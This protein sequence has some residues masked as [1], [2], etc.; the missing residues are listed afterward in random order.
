MSGSHGYAHV[1]D[2]MYYKDIKV[3]CGKIFAVGW[4]G[5]LFAHELVAG[6]APSQGCDVHV[7]KEEPD[8]A[9]C[10][11][12]NYHLVISSNKNKLF[13][14]RWSLPPFNIGNKT[15]HHSMSL[16]VFEADLDNG[17]WSEVKDLGNRVL[18]VGTTGSRAFTVAGQPEHYDG[19][20]RGGNRVFLLC[21]DRKRLANG[22]PT[23][24]VYDMTSRKTSLVS[25]ASVKHSGRNGSSPR[26]KIQKFQL[27]DGPIE[28][29]T[30]TSTIFI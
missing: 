22:N 2:Y 24:C 9:V 13:L 7:I 25:L 3:H 12:A 10:P 15:D 18:F 30:T 27:R 1:D 8:A 28:I 6:V 4:R 19:T 29:H 17:R 16:R 23:Y 26:C 5:H 11:I 20:F 14:V 21:N